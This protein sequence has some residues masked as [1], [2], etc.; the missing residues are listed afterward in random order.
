MKKIPTL[1]QRNHETDHRVRDEVTPGCEWVL[2]GEGTATRKWDGICCLVKGGKLFKRQEVKPLK[3]APDG[4]LPVSMPDYKTSDKIIGWVP[5]GDGPEDKWHLEA[6]AIQNPM[7]EGTYELIG[8]KINGNPENSGIHTL[9]PHGLNIIPE[10]V[11][12]RSF[13]VIREFLVECNIEGIVWHHPDGRMAKI[14]GKDFGIKRN[15]KS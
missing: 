13:R 10:P 11:V 9:V 7:Q 1:F 14:K 15:S 4:F 3:Q 8:P 6:F 5:V 12:D 2:A